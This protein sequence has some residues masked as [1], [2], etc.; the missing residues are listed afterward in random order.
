MEILKHVSHVL[1]KTLRLKV[2]KNCK[3]D[4]FSE[5]L[6][7]LDD[8]CCTTD[9]TQFRSERFSEVM[10][11]IA[12]QALQR[13]PEPTMHDRVRRSVRHD[14]PVRPQGLPARVRDRAPM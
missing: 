1:K 13:L 10:D 7:E 2:V 12:Y 3:S 6:E 14:S 11:V 4:D 8:R 5:L 9:L